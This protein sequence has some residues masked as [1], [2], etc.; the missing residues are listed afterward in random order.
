MP[1]ALRLNPLVRRGKPTVLEPGHEPPSDTFLG[2]RLAR[3]P[4]NSP[5]CL[6]QVLDEQEAMTAVLCQNLG[7]RHLA[8]QQQIMNLQVWPTIRSDVRLA[9]FIRLIRLR[10]V[11]GDRRGAGL[12]LNSDET[13]SRGA[14]GHHAEIA[15]QPIAV[16]RPNASFELLPRKIGRVG[17]LSLKIPAKM[18]CSLKTS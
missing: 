15:R 14:A 18:H 13:S 9:E 1:D 10:K 17:A 3:V 5:A 6:A 7:D 11:H 2:E 16:E 4:G 12:K 8:S